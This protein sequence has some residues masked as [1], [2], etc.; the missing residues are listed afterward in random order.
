VNARKRKKIIFRPSCLSRAA[1]VSWAA[2]PCDT[3]SGG[4][5]T[6]ENLQIGF[7]TES[8]EDGSP[9]LQSVS[10]V[11]GF[12]TNDNEIWTSYNLCSLL[13]HDLFDCRFVG[14]DVGHS[15]YGAIYG[16]CPHCSNVSITFI[17]KHSLVLGA[18]NVVV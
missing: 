18:W 11:S 14:Y 10:A 4:C 1:A 17:A 3:A 8:L 12:Q 6:V 13:Q 7:L 16:G 5:C 2:S 9:C 15:G